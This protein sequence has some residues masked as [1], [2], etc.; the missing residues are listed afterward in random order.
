MNNETRTL[1]QTHADYFALHCLTDEREYKEVIASV[2][3]WSV[4]FLG[5]RWKAGMR[6]VAIVSLP[7]EVNPKSAVVSME[8]RMLTIMLAK[9]APDLA[10]SSEILASAQ[11]FWPRASSA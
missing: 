10:E 1:L 8:D 4:V 2:S 3:P 6:I 11:S 9:V 5:V 7:Q